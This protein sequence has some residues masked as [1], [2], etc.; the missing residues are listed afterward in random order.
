M[1]SRIASEK[2]LLTS[3]CNLRHRLQ[4]LIKCCTAVALKDGDGVSARMGAPSTV[5]AVGRRLRVAALACAMRIV[6]MMELLR[7]H[8]FKM[9]HKF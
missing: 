1:K 6:A 9:L 2:E 8:K 3:I 7:I 5:A 4:M